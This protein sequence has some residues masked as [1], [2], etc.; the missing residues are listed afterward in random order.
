MILDQFKNTILPFTLLYEGGY[1]NTPSTDHGCETYRGISRV[2]NPT[3]EG[4]PIVDSLKPLKRGDVINH[5][6]LKAA[7]ANL[8]YYRYFHANKFDFISSPKVALTLFDL[9]VHGGYSVYMIQNILNTKFSKTLLVDGVC[10]AKTI[11]AINETSDLELC[12]EINKYRT[13][14]F[15]KIVDTD[16]TQEPNLE[17]WMNRVKKLNEYLKKM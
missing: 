13:T 7:V 10:G 8:Y 17:G 1:V 16:P 14:R 3:W 6:G 11:A 15:K 9:A 2:N 12:T 4:W 5:A